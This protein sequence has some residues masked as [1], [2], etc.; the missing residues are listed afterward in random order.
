MTA[1]PRDTLFDSERAGYQV[2]RRDF[3]RLLLAEA[4]RAGAVVLR[5]TVVRDVRDDADP[6]SEYPSA[7][8]GLRAADGGAASLRARLVLDC[9][10][11]AG[12]LARQ[13]G[14]RVPIGTTT[15]AFIGVWRRSDGWRAPHDTHTCVE[16]YADGWAWSVPVSRTCRYVTVMVDPRTTQAGGEDN[17]P[18][19]YA[20]EIR[21]TTH[22]A[23]LIAGAT[24]DG[25]PWA[26]DASHYTTR[27]FGGPRFLLVGDAATFIDPLSSFGVKK[28]MASACVAAT[29]ANTMLTDPARQELA[30]G[31]YADREAAVF[32]SYRRSAAGFFAEV[33]EHHLHRFWSDRA[34]LEPHDPT[35]LEH[36]TDIERLRGDPEVQAAFTALRT[37]PSI[38]LRATGQVRTTSVAAIAGRE[39]IAE[40][41]FVLEAGGR[42]S[43]RFLRGVDLMSLARVAEKHAQVPDLYAAYQ[44]ACAPVDLPDFL[45]ALS[46][47]LGKGVLRNDADER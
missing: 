26:L 29:V 37:A 47:L 41:R 11:R 43:V 7:A 1:P 4:E 45:G 32:E 39:I 14:T 17:L 36:D 33:S 18:G 16:A 9:S 15:V 40:H 2:V 22:V 10:G 44:S 25:R 3:D 21:K 19:R 34:D 13:Y 38:R 30:L 8:L 20:A 42:M 28:A 27:Q 23:E 31:F 12:V 6:S 24:L 35:D 5:D 46:V